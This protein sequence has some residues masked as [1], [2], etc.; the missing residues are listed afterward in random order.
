VLVADII[1]TCKEAIYY[2]GREFKS[3]TFIAMEESEI[4]GFRVF[5]T[6][7]NPNPTRPD[8]Q[9]VDPTRPENPKFGS[10]FRVGSGFGTRCRTW[11][12]SEGIQTALSLLLSKPKQKCLGT[13]AKI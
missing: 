3:Y 4:S 1:R 11:L 13:E 10:G 2:K 7:P 12:A 9:N 6:D 5:T 8:F